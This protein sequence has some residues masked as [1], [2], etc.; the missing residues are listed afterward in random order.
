MCCPTD[1]RPTTDAFTDMTAS[2]ERTPAGRPAVLARLAAE[3]DKQHVE[4]EPPRWSR[5]AGRLLVIA[6]VAVILFMV[7]TVHPW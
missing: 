6:I 1:P 2:D 7:T 3:A 4:H 5:W